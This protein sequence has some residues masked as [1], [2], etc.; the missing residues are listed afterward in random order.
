MKE[1]AARFLEN[2]QNIG[3]NEAWSTSNWQELEQAYNAPRRHYHNLQHLENLFSLFEQYREQLQEP[4]VVSWTI[5]YHDIIYNA[6]RK[7]N[8]LRSAELARKRL[9]QTAL[10]PDKIERV[11]QYIEA[12]AQHLSVEAHEDLAYFL[13]FDLAI[14]GTDMDTYAVY[15]KAIRQEYQHVPGFLYRRGRRKVLRYFADAPQ[16][17]R[18]PALHI[19]FAK[20]AQRNLSWELSSITRSPQC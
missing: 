17:F 9:Q 12:T 5:W 15:A 4:D 18:T 1:L 11:V 10:A 7:D 19:R 3:A 2:A 20:Q 16:L 14:L 6:K 8:E 13:D